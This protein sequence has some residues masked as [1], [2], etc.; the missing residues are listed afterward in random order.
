M[1]RLVEFLR[2]R[3][4]RDLETLTSLRE[5]VESASSTVTYTCVVRG[6]RECEVKA[7][8]LDV[9]QRCGAGGGPCDRTGEAYRSEDERGCF[10][11]AM[12]GLPYSDD[13]EYRSWWRP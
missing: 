11:R 6:F 2:K 5:E 13:P 9:H 3:I 10:T 4:L 12:L 7:R 8:L 1:D